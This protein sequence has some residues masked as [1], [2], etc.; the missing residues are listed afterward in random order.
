MCSASAVQQAAYLQAS[1]S[2]L[3][4]YVLLLSFVFLSQQAM[5]VDCSV[6]P[7]VSLRGCKETRVAHTL[8]TALHRTGGCCKFSVVCISLGWMGN[9]WDAAPEGLC[10]GC[11]NHVS[12]LQQSPC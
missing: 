8:A 6:G 5:L 9:S 12:E 10:S 7:T 3:S 1:I 11:S 4:V 2:F